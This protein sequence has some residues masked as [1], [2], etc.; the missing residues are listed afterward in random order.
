MSLLLNICL[1]VVSS[2]LL[3]Q[4]VVAQQTEQAV[5]SRSVVRIK[6]PLDQVYDQ[7]RVMLWS[8]QKIEDLSGIDTATTGVAYLTGRLMVD[9]NKISLEPRLARLHLASKCYREA[10][11]RVEVK[12]LPEQSERADLTAALARS[13]I[14]LVGASGP[15]DSLQID[16]DARANE[17][18]FYL[19]LLRD[20]HQQLPKLPLSITALASW[21]QGDRWLEHESE[22]PIEYM[23]PMFFTMGAGKERALAILKDSLP[24]GYNGRRV[25]GLSLSEPGTFDLVAPKLNQIDHVY[26]F[27]SP[28][29]N[30]ERIKVASS[31]IKEK[32]L[33]EE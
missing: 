11:V 21:S 7:P 2:L 18:Q 19:Q 13:I 6:R 9:G 17:R 25:L 14:N 16:F 26:L 28:G 23:V 4:S 10:V 15:I 32:L 24:A 5:P 3:G 12:A 22:V 8:W 33:K 29:W 27:C 1:A 30:K 31:L 20:L